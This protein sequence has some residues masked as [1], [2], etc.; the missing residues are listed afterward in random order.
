MVYSN[1][2]DLLSQVIKTFSAQPEVREITIFGRHA[3]G[4]ADKYSDIDIRI[5]SN[6]T[7]RTQEKYLSLFSRIS[8]IRET[9]LLVSDPDNLAQMI[10]L[11]EYSLY[12]KVDF[13]I[14]SGNSPFTP[15][16]SVYKNEKAKENSS[17]MKV[18][19]IH[20]D[21]KYNLTNYL[22]GVPRIIKCFFRNDFDMYRRWKDMTNPVL[23]L[24]YQKYNGYQ[25]D[26]QKR[27]SD[28]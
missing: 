3:E 25:K 28:E 16:V 20:Q 1:R 5:H 9:F 8:P 14:C 26:E 12:Q 2:V 7:L 6:N 21:V 17:K 24:L 13:G 10:M 23:A 27:E 22:F 18:L 19:K 15:S 11:T 4:A